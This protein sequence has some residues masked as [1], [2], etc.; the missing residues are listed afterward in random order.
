VSNQVRARI[1]ISCG[2]Q[3]NTVEEKIADEIK[4]KL[5]SMGFECYVAVTEQTLRGV[6]ENILRRLSES[7][8]LVFVDFIRERLFIEEK[9]NFADTGEH[10]GS[11]FSNQELAIATYLDIDCIAFQEQGVRELDGI[12]R[13][14]QAN[15]TT[16]TDRNSLPN[17]IADKVKEK[18]S[19]GEWNPHWRNEL[20]LKRSNPTEYELVNDGGENPDPTRFFHIEVQN[21]HLNRIAHDCVGYIE[22]IE[23]LSTN[24]ITIPDLVELKWKGTITLRIAIPPQKS[25]HLDGFY[26]RHVMPKTVHLGINISVVD[27]TGY[28]NLYTL[29]SANDCNLTYVVF[30]NNFPPA[31]RTFRLHMGNK[32]D[33]IELSEFTATSQIQ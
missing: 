13:F 30:S 5:D 24:E 32:L 11:L 21:L 25:R 23:N 10:R 28:L 16:F 3:K 22:K 9:G 27:Y 7:E 14:I 1:F 8:Y 20:V 33:D 15:C 31:R 2:Q 26:V 18:I 12:L 19:R 17:Q 4:A 6:K 29:W